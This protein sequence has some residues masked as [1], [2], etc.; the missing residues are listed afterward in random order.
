MCATGAKTVAIAVNRCA[1]AVKIGVID[2][3]LRLANRSPA[4][5]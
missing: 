1:T 3:V 5:K 2:A 4:G